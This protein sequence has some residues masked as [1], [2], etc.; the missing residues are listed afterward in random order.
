MLS[1]DIVPDRQPLAQILKMDG[2][3]TE[4]HSV[5]ALGSSTG[6]FTGMSGTFMMDSCTAKLDLER[7]AVCEM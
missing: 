7:L 3:M 5:S 1:K 6:T 4:Y 2:G